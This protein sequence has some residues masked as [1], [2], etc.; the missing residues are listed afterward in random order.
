MKTLLFAEFVNEHLT[1]LSK[2]FDEYFLEDFRIN[3]E[4][5]E[6][7]FKVDNIMAVN[8]ST[9]LENKLIELSCDNKLKKCSMK[10]LLK[11]FGYHCNMF[12]KTS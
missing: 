3:Q 1:A 9:G 5:I 11:F 8:V 7:S 6:T 10:I 4:W 2:S 12:H